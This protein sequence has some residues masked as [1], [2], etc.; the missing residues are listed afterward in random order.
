LVS[1]LCREG[2]E[3]ASLYAGNNREGA[4]RKTILMA[5]VLL[6]FG[7]VGAGRTTA[8]SAEPPSPAA[9]RWEYRALTKAKL[10]DLGKND[11]EAGLNQLGDEGWELVAVDASFTYT[12]KRPKGQA[13]KQLEDVKAQISLI[14]ADVESLKD[15][16]AWAE[17]MARKGFMTDQQVQAERARLKRA[18]AALDRARRELKALPSDPR[19]PAEK[20]RQPEK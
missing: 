18:E 12:F 19:G 7:V 10:L 20:E 8:R 2:N 13:Q 9:P 15:R 5:F 11:L 3:K 14:E 1:K 17:R 4:M 6:A 16:V